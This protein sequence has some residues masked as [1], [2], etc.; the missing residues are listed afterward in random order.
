MAY[1]EFFV[2]PGGGCGGREP[3]RD[4]MR[5]LEGRKQICPG[6]EASGGVRWASLPGRRGARVVPRSTD[7]GVESV[8]DQ[9]LAGSSGAGSVDGSDG[10]SGAGVRLGGSG[11]G[12]A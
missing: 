2:C 9:T 3:V 8:S 4:R 12:S 11:G 1:G 7:R 6:R 5:G 10:V